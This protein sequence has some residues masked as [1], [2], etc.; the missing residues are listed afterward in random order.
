MGETLVLNL[1]FAVNSQTST[2]R[3][4][5]TVSLTIV[6]VVQTSSYVREIT[7]T[8]WITTINGY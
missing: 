8:S 2:S 7:S 6:S 5:Q 4:H 3:N 1:F